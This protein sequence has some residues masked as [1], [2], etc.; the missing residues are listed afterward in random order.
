MCHPNC[1][2]CGS[3]RVKKNGSAWKKK[4]KYQCND[5]KRR[6]VENPQN[7]I[8]SDSE[9]KITDR[10]LLE[11]IPLAGIACAM[12]VSERWLQDYVNKKHTEIP[13]ETKVL[14]KPKGRLEIEAD[15]LWSFAGGK[16]NK[17]W[18][19]LAVDRNTRER[20]GCF[21]G[22]RGGE[23]AGGLWGSFPPVYRQCGVTRTDFRESYNCVFPK[24]RHRAAG[25]ETGLTCHIERLNNTFRQRISGSVRKT[26]SFSKKQKIIPGRYGILSIIIILA[27]RLN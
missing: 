5:C 25:W 9:K 11:K 4:Q 16:D 20:T 13:D 1:P 6:F 22:S 26:L 2:V 12:N 14:E 10:L 21:A 3:S 7:K 18:V 19:W 23:G 24:M 15:E 27:L 8:I 17:Q